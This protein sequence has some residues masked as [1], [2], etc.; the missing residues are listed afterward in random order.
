MK[1]SIY[2]WV[3]RCCFRRTCSRVESFAGALSQAEVQKLG[4]GTSHPYIVIM[5]N[6]LTGADAIND[7]APVMSELD[8]VQR[9]SASSN[10]A[11][12]TRWPPRSP[13]P[14]LRT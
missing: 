1:P 2:S 11:P 10:S 5:K 6:Q 3:R 7:Q 13:K 4:S 8:Q 12:S 9:R 14:R